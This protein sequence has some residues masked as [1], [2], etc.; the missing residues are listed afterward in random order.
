MCAF[1]NQRGGQVLFGVT[2][3]GVVVGQ[4]VSERTIEELSAEIQRIDPPAFPN[5]ERV[6]MHGDHEVVVVSTNQGTSRPYTY[7]GRAYR[8]VGNTTLA[9][10]ADEYNLILFERMHSEQRWKTGPP[11]DGRLETSTY[12]KSVGQWQKRSGAGAW[13]IL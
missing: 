7:R 2:A 6:R 12:R 5:I 13:M 4:Q 8:R 3:A 10:S 9:M 1:L 11:Q